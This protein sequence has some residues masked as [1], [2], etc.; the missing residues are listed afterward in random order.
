MIFKRAVAKL[1]A[2]DWMAIAIELAIVV[3][4][5]FVGTQ[6]SN[7]NPERIEA[8]QTRQ[9]LVQLLPEL[10]VL[11]RFSA[12]SRLYYATT[13]NYARIA[14]A[15]WRGDPQV[16]DSDFIIAA[17]QASQIYGFNNNGGSWA[18]TFGANELRK[19]DD[20]ALREPLT[21]LMTFDYE[22]LNFPAV[23]SRY[24]DAVREVISDEI[25]QSIRAQCGDRL[26]PDGRT[27]SLVVPC[28]LRLDH[29][30]AA[31]AAADLRRHPELVRL[32]RQHR[33][34]IA[35]YLT[36]LDLYDIQERQL[37]RRVAALQ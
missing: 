29:A 31:S 10:K 13:G 22:T 17:Y 34:V 14:F 12:K 11:E 24:R 25:Q 26:E 27:I 37:A 7:W 16:S 2:Q 32:L 8:R 1:R 5:V 19:I 20:V 6:V 30:A 18:L 36:N 23:S 3:I 15:G 21:R 28:P 9:M 33:S 4:G 35:T